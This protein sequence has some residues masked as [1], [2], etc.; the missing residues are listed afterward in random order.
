[1]SGIGGGAAEAGLQ[2]ATNVQTG[3]RWVLVMFFN[4]HRPGAPSS[5]LGPKPSRNQAPGAAADLAMTTH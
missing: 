4:R 2:A 1:M 3:S 5:A